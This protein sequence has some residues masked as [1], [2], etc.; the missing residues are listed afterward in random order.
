MNSGEGWWT[1][2]GCDD[3]HYIFNAIEEKKQKKAF[4][5]P[6]ER[7][8]LSQDIAQY[9]DERINNREMKGS[10]NSDKWKVWVACGDVIK[11]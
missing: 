11:P 5:F 9:S 6:F 4:Q 3:V 8:W 1:S 2:Y 10:K 7:L